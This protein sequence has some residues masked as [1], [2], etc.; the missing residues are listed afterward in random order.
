MLGVQQV[1]YDTRMVD[2]IGVGWSFGKAGVKYY[3][4]HVNEHGWHA[5]LTNLAGAHPEGCAEYRFSSPTIINSIV[6][7]LLSII[8]LSFIRS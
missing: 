6:S 8:G 3:P 4:C 1:P 7:H 5:Y 2:L